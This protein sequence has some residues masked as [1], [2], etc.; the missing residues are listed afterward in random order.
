MGSPVI[1]IQ[2]SQQDVLVDSTKELTFSTPDAQSASAIRLW[3]NGE[4]Q[5]DNADEY[6][7]Q[8]SL[9]ETLVTIENASVSDSGVYQLEIVQGSHLM[10]SVDIH[11]F[12][13]IPQGMMRI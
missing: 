13:L 3:H 5:S 10:F 11:I 2:K 4:L 9:S 1:T 12:V 7:I 8:P 6:F